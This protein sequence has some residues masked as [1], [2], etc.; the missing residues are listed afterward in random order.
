[1]TAPEFLSKQAILGHNNRQLAAALGVPET[2]ISNWSNGKREVPDYIAK[3][4]ELLAGDAIVHITFPI[5][6]TELFAL[7]RLAEAR[8]ITVEALL[9]D[10]IRRAL[11]PGLHLLPTAE[12]TTKVAMVSGLPPP[13]L[14]H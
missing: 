12:A 8:K 6:L 1:M 5:S 13:P 2:S 11:T 10:L 3:H 7:S 14:D 4:L 9:V